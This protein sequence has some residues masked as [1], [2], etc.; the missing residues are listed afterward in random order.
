M[1]QLKKVNIYLQTQITTKHRHG[2]NINKNID[3]IYKNIKSKNTK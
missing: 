2:H 1:K 3:K